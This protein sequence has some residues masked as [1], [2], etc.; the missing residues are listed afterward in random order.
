MSF[1]SVIVKLF[2]SLVIFFTSVFSFP[3]QGKW[4]AVINQTHKYYGVSKSVFKES[5]IFMRIKCVDLSDMLTVRIN[6][7][8]RETP[9]WDEYWRLELL[10]K[11]E[12]QQIWNIYY[13]DSVQ[14]TNVAEFQDHLF[15][16]PPDEYRH[17]CDNTIHL[18]EYAENCTLATSTSGG[19]SSGTAKNGVQG[20][21]TFEF[22]MCQND[23]SS[24]AIVQSS[25]PV[26]TIPKDGV[27][28][29]I[30][31]FEPEGSSEF[32]AEVEVQIKGPHGYLSATE[33]PLLIFYGS[34]CLLYTL[35]GVVWLG[36]SFWQWRDLIRIQFWIGA[37]IF[38]GMAV[39]YAEYYNINSTG[40]S[41]TGAVLVA[42][43]ISCA[44]RTLARMLVVI[45]SIGFGIVKPRLGATLHRILIVGSLY[46][47]FASFE[48][49]L[50]VLHPVNGPSNKAL[51]AGVPLSILD[52]AIFYWIFQS[53]MA[54]TRT[55]RLRRNLIKLNLYRHFTNT[56][57]FAVISSIIFM[58][59]SIRYLKTTTCLRDWKEI[60]IDE[61]YWHMLFS[62]ILL[63]IMVLWRPSNNNQRFAFSP[64]LD[65]LDDDD[66]ED[67]VVNS[68]FSG[69]MKLRPKKNGATNGKLYGRSQS[70]EDELRWVEENI[71][72]DMAEGDLPALDSE[73]EL[74]STKFELS[75]MQ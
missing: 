31:K 69:N 12:R 11:E 44:K 32:H 62:L 4:N 55:L 8:L 74:L 35:Y 13:A 71:P 38:L 34:S 17:R 53:L 22:Q 75:K 27:Y 51:M 5:Q 7:E 2:I 49:C 70:V 20:Q 43:I 21:S 64:L 16:K 67:L 19:K 65:N 46:F 39:F 6:W 29:F 48:S 41:V 1:T 15:F 3:E 36:L 26:F 68:A 61:A 60:W 40:V 23:V 73:E 25:R 52:A 14:N 28:L 33:Y 66:E 63:V 56:L 45:V 59:W 58:V 24:S 42:E 50:R 37:V 57:F 54:T 30:V 10:S 9:C 18:T 47:A 72:A